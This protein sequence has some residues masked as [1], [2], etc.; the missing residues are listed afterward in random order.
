MLFGQ[1]IQRKRAVGFSFENH[2]DHDVGRI[3]LLLQK[4]YRVHQQLLCGK[5]VQAGEEDHSGMNVRVRG[6]CSEVPGIFRYQ[7]QVRLNARSKDC[8]VSLVQA[9][10]IARMYNMVPVLGTRFI[11][12][13]R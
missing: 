10:L 1:V 2:F 5:A 4:L 3:A 9:T 6:K 12:Q 13:S 8:M 7:Q 11:G